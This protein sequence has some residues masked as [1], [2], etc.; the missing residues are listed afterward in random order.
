MVRPAVPSIDELYDQ[1]PYF[2][3]MV[4][5]MLNKA[6]IWPGGMQDQDSDQAVVPLMLVKATAARNRLPHIS[7]IRKLAVQ[8]VTEFTFR[9]LMHAFGV[10]NESAGASADLDMQYRTSLE[11]FEHLESL[12]L[13]YPHDPERNVNA[14]RRKADEMHD[15]LWRARDLR[16]LDLEYESPDPKDTEGEVGNFE[17]NLHLLP[18]FSSPNI[19]FPHLRELK[20]MAAIPGQAFATFLSLHSGTLKSLA[21]EFCSSD[22][23]KVVMH[24]IAKSLKPDYLNIWMLH[25]YYYYKGEA[26]DGPEG[27]EEWG[28]SEPGWRLGI[29]DLFFSGLVE[30]E[31]NQGCDQDFRRALRA[32][33]A[34]EGDGELHDEYYRMGC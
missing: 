5:D 34:G 9:E 31:D 11:T 20:I 17:F 24:T 29:E 15:L 30:D 27:P 23:W 28:P 26:I 4:R 6:V 14:N 8:M 12:N 32:Y 21:I 16:V 19:T 22:N 33:F 25:E 13:S 2:K 18:W 7:P 1:K 10:Y 3:C